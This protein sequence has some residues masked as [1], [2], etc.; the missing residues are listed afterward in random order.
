[1]ITTKRFQKMFKSNM[2]VNIYSQKI[3]LSK[4]IST[5]ANEMLAIEISDEEILYAL[6]QINPLKAPSPNDIQDIFYHKSWSNN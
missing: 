4:D 6:K 2:S 3:P 5:A 1:M